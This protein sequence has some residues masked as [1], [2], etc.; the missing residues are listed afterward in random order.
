MAFYDK[1]LNYS[2]SNQQS[3]INKQVL[4]VLV[5]SN[6]Q[7][8]INKQVLVVLVIYDLSG[9]MML[10][11]VPWYLTRTHIITIFI[12]W[13]Y[14]DF[15]LCCAHLFSCSLYFWSIIGILVDDLWRTKKASSQVRVL[16]VCVDIAPSWW[17]GCRTLSINRSTEKPF[18]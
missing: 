12:T 11:L 10:L 9:K 8:T 6:Q 4:V 2:T 1:P 13:T 17:C 3:T 7:S 15:I 5:I 16:W 14:A 18:K